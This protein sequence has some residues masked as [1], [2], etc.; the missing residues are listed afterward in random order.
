MATAK[1]TSPLERVTPA[2][3]DHLKPK[4]QRYEL[5]DNGKHGL[6]LRV[7]PSERKSFVWCYKN[8]PKTR[9][10]TLGRYGSA[11]GCVSMKTA[12]D[13]LD[14]ARSSIGTVTAQD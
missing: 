5:P 13:A 10:L 14:K 7:E 3:L 9:I 12:R 8:L 6:R 2:Y 4:A 11:E 1:H